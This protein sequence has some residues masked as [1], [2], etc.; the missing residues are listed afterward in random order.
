LPEEATIVEP[1][2]PCHRRKRDGFDKPPKKIAR[3]RVI[4]RGVINARAMRLNV[5]TS[6]RVGNRYPDCELPQGERHGVT[7]RSRMKPLSSW[8]V[9]LSWR[10]LEQRLHTAQIF[11]A[12]P[13]TL[14]FFSVAVTDEGVIAARRDLTNFRPHARPHFR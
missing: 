13:P 7:K 2:G 3:M 1:V 4:V 10:S 11:S 14:S 12:T 9:R 8:A 6:V 5:G